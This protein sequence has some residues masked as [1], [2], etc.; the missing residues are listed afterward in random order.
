MEFAGKLIKGTIAGT[1]KNLILDVK[2]N[3]GSIQPVFCPETSCINN[4]YAKGADVWVSPAD[5]ERRR[6]KYEVQLINKGEGLI[7]A[8]PRYISQLFA[9]AFD[10]G[11]LTDFDQYK[12][13]RRIEYGED[14][15]RA[16]F[17]LS[18]DR[19]EKCYVYAV[20]IYNK[21]GPYVV[22][23]SYINF[24]EMEMFDE[25]KKL[26]AKGYKTA[27]VMIALRMDC[28]EAK[29]VWNLDQ[30][31]AARIFDEAKSGLNF[32]CYGCNINQK[33]VTITQKVK[34][35]Y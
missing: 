6:L 15:M 17:E 7:L 28:L 14:V 29:F 19:G 20:G 26:R 4:L 3:D 35:L 30:I 18:D 24:Y 31:A 34:I 21:L 12:Y 10:E 5:D 1:Y 16:H 27:V 8:N 23:P 22:F 9:E 2:F 25:L 11:I 13:L 33:S 32:F